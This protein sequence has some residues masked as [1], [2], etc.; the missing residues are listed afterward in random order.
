MRRE[1]IVHVLEAIGAGNILPHGQN[2]Q[3]SC[4]LA[5]WRR[6]HKS[7]RDS[8]PS[9]GI[10][11]NENE[12]SMVH[13]FACNYG[14][15]IEMAISLLQFSSQEDLSAVLRTIMVEETADPEWLADN[16][17]E[18]EEQV[19]VYKDTLIPESEIAG[20]MGIAHKY[21][22]DRNFGIETLKAWQGGYDDKRQRVVFP[23]RNGK[24]QLVGMVGRTIHGPEVKPKYLNYFEFDRGRYLFGEHMVTPGTALVVAEGLL[25]P[26][27][28]WQALRKA[29]LLGSYSVVSPLGSQTTKY[30]RKRMVELT[31]EVIMFLDNDTAGWEGQEVVAQRIQ[32]QVVLKSVRYPDP[33]GGDPAEF[34]EERPEIDI[35]QLIE[36]ADLLIV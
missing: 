1:A 9:M 4:F 12:D 2:V 5:K 3:C 34:L 11:V 19:E 18:Y 36:N 26:V 21:I 22:L 27:A 13:C 35:V 29:D 32:D 14:G 10:S 23:V 15:T 17:P 25:D 28:V 16:I 20:M 7:D 6:G 24:G 8:K 31:D 33:V 30:Q